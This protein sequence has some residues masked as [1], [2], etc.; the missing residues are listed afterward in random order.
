MVVLLVSLAALAGCR[1]LNGSAKDAGAKKDNEPTKPFMG[2][3]SGGSGS[4]V[5]ANPVPVIPPANQGATVDGI[6]AG[7][8]LDDNNRNR[9]GVL[10]QVV[11]LQA[12]QQGSNAAPVSM[13]ANPQGF[14]VIPG[15]KPGR[16]YQLIAR[17][18]DGDRTLS[19]IA[20]AMP[21]NPR[22]NI[23]MKEDPK[24]G[25]GPSGIPAPKS[26]P[27]ATLEAPTK[28]GNDLPSTPPVALPHTSPGNTPPSSGPGAGWNPQPS[29][30]MIPP[31]PARIADNTHDGFN[32]YPP[33]SPK[34]I[35]PP[36]VLPPPPPLSG[37]GSTDLIQ[38]PP[39]PVPV[40]PTFTPGLGALND[41]PPPPV[42]SCVLVGKQL[43]N[44]ALYGMDGKPWVYRRDRT[45]RLLLI[46]FWFSTCKP[47]LMTVPYLRD[48]QQRY[49]PYKLEVIGIAYEKGSLAE[50]VQRVRGARGRYGIDYPTL[51]GGNGQGP[52][53]VRTQFGVDSFPTLVLID[54]EG[55]IVWRSVGFEP[56]EFKVLDLEIRRR[57]GVHLP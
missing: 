30:N 2:L 34:V 43:H 17:V 38:P 48:L 28:L 35:I 57:L 8:V 4:A 51:L 54:E 22:L 23:L 49:G 21:P 50:Q 7:Y 55:K 9:P 1:H 16:H 10:I 56:E 13:E 3:D 39:V 42:P 40:N 47:C 45:G 52:C 24:G 12:Q 32:V 11:D 20:L 25:T 36:P 37:S 5:T 19:G 53:P 46:D 44:F 6:L 29:G 41:E 15:L 18:K 14:F 31:S 33:P 26:G 27:A